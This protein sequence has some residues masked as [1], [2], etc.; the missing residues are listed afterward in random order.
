[1]K[2]TVEPPSS[3]STA[4]LTCRSRTPSSSAILPSMDPACVDPL[5]PGVVTIPYR[6]LTEVAPQL[7]QVAPTV[8]D[9][10][11]I[12]RAG[13]RGWRRGSDPAAASRGR[14][15][16]EEPGQGPEGQRHDGG[17]GA[18]DL[19]QDVGYR[20]EHENPLSSP[21]PG[22][23]GGPGARFASMRADR[24]RPTSAPARTGL[25]SVPA[26][27][28]L[29]SVPA[30]TDRSARRPVPA[31]SACRY[32]PADQRARRCLRGR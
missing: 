26:C 2:G 13:S 24:C 4:A 1:M 3:S 11:G 31:R 22:G 9:Q 21:G 18:T 17:D 10:G 28:G 7:W 27:T 6:L 5:D 12:R 20:S 25:I 19:P 14:G 30:G 32:V 15:P 16:A 8:V 23:R 29:I